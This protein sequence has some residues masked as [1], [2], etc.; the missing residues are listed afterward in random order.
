MNTRSEAGLS[1]KPV[2]PECCENN[3]L[4]FLD[5]LRES[6]ETN[7]WGGGQYVEQ[8]FGLNKHDAGAILLYWMSTFSTR[9]P[10]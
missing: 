8:H 3:H 6:G 10:S 2:R 5:D 7:M 9:H 4:E 1:P